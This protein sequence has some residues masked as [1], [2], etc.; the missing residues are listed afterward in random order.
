MRW[1]IPAEKR[2]Q[3]KKS[4]ENFRNKKHII[5]INNISNGLMHKLDTTED[6]TSDFE[7][8]SMEI[9]EIT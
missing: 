3:S 6:V 9:T 2:K 8:K 5:D 7:Y 4:K 1:I